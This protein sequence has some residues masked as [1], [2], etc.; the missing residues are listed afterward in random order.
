MRNHP[1]DGLAL[2]RESAKAR[3]HQAHHASF[4]RICEEVIESHHERWDGTGYPYRLKGGGVPFPARLCA[5]ADTYDAITEHRLYSGPPSTSGPARSSW[6][7]LGGS[8]TRSWWKC[9]RPPARNS[10][11]SA[12]GSRP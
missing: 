5:I 7:R 2:F 1:M 3:F 10:R 12:N 6:R 4:V 9:S 8:L 11:P